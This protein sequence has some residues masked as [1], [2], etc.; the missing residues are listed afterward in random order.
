MKMSSRVD[1]YMICESISC[2][3]GLREITKLL[4]DF[5]GVILCDVPA[6]LRNDL[7][8]YCCGHRL[9]VYIAPKISDILMRGGDELRLF[10]TPLILCRNEGLSPEKRFLKRGFDLLIAVLLL[11]L[12]SPVMLICAAAVRLEDGGPVFYRQRR[13]TRDGKEFEMLKFRSMIPDAEA[14]G[15]PVLAADHDARITKTGNILRRFRLDELPQLLNILRGEMSLV[16]P[17]PERPELAEIYAKKHPEFSYRL[18]VKAGLT[19]YA[20]VIGTYDTEPI[21]KLKMDLMYIEQYSLLLDIQ[22]LLLTLKTALFPPE[23]NAE[24]FSASHS[25]SKKE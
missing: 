19:G 22:I 2:A 7:L 1:K 14:D 9:R 15:K 24:E 25:D 5:D 13:L 18:Q 11:L 23:T 4:C 3:A 20:Q 6:E 21:D 17:R 16:G 12:L 8:K 10:D